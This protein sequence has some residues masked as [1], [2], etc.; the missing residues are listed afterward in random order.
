MFSSGLL[1][2]VDVVRKEEK[3]RGHVMIRQL[4]LKKHKNVAAFLDPF[5]VILGKGDLFGFWY[6]HLVKGKERIINHLYNI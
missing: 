2:G 3:T 4:E 6:F 5:P 1:K